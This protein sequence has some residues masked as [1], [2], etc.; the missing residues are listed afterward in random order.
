MANSKFAKDNT[1][2][3][4]EFLE[5]VHPLDFPVEATGQFA[6]IRLSLKTKGKTIG[7]YDL[8]IAAH[9]RHMGA[10]LVTNDV[11]EFSAVPGLKLQNWLSA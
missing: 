9:A 10:V 6:A 4:N 11:R 5:I 2:R 1:L 3:L 8:L 7:P